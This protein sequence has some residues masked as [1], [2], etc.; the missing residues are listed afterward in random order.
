M[1]ITTGPMVR[2]TLA[3]GKKTKWTGT[4]SL[5]GKTARSMRVT[6]STISVR[7]RA[8]SF[9]LT[10]ANTLDSGK[11]VN[12]TESAPTSARMVSPSRVSGRTD[13]RL[14]GSMRMAWLMTSKTI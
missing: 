9:G 1:E 2:P 10:D 14:D 13:A 11:L 8:T 4:V 6:S 5:L 12:S 7:A 3:T